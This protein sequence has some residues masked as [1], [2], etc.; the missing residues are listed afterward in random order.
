MSNSE[1][2]FSQFRLQL[3]QM[4]FNKRDDSLM[5]LVDALASN[6]Q[7][8]S[9][10]EL[11]LSPL[12]RRDYNSLFKAIAQYQSAWVHQNLA[13]LAAPSLPHPQKRPFYLL[14]VDVTSVPVPMPLA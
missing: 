8:H 2:Q 14:G 4:H 10:V 6:T 3:Y 7:A 1:N 12:F 13:Q 9:V 11:S 5:D